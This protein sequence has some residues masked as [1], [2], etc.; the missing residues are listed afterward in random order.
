MV[1][2]K[3]SRKWRISGLKPLTGN[4]LFSGFQ[5]NRL[6]VLKTSSD[7]Q[8][9]EQ[10]ARA[11]EAFAGFGV[12]KVLEQ[13]EGVL[14]LERAMPG[15]PLKK[16]FPAQ[17]CEVVQIACE[18]IRKLHNAPLPFGG[19]FSHIMDWLSLLDKNWDIPA[20][21]LNKARALRDNLLAT[22]KQEVLL[23]GDLH[24]ENILH[25]GKDFVVIDPKG[26]IGEGA[27]E[28][29]AFIR[30]PIPRLLDEPDVSN[31]IKTRI[32]GFAAGLYLDPDRIFGWCFVQ[33]VL[34]WAWA[35]E[36][37]LDTGYFKRF[38]GCLY[39]LFDFFG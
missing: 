13:G 7:I 23:H 8:S 19:E 39:N 3:F 36:D 31:I 27:Y 30:N 14:L 25:S 22:Q 28:V 12:V 4:H 9:L 5:D 11:L 20:A 18:V 6:V 21:Y 16:L 1:L 38:S 26:V 2:N 15:E 10:E 37:G 32:N 33:T 34:A 24:H 29:G 17:D 35:L